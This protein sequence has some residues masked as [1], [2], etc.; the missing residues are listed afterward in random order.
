MKMYPKSAKFENHLSILKKAQYVPYN[1][2]S[3]QSL[4]FT[5]FYWRI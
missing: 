4:L 2:L 5:S 3:T 1:N